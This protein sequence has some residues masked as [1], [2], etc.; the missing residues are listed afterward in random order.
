MLMEKLWSISKRIV[1]VEDVA[2]A[3]KLPNADKVYSY[4]ECSI[5]GT[6]AEVGG[7]IW[8][9]KEGGGVSFSF[10]FDM[11]DRELKL[12]SIEVNGIID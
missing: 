8:Y 4:S 6:N 1:F 10:T 7:I 5:S 2:A 3:W 12:K 11:K 9:M